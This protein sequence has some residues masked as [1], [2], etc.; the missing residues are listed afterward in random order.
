MKT[1]AIILTCMGMLSLYSNQAYA[2]ERPT[3]RETDDSRTLELILEEARKQAEYNLIEAKCEIVML[4]T[5][6]KD[7]HE[8]GCLSLLR[9]F[10]FKYDTNTPT[11]HDPQLWLKKY[12][13]FG[14]FAVPK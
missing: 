9:E 4:V 14:E 10:I 5:D 13:P 7:E 11:N 2:F 1:L 12:W 3:E 6:T 8:K